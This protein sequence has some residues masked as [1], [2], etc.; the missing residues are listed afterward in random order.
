MLAYMGLAHIVHP[1]TRAANRSPPGLLV[2]SNVGRVDQQ[3]AIPVLRAVAE[4][5]A[6]LRLLLLYGSRARGDAHERSDWDVGYLG[7]DVDHL[8]LLADVTSALGTDDVDLVDF[9]RASGLLTFRAAREGITVYER[10]PGIWAEFALTA[11]LHWYDVEP[12][13]RRTHADLLAGLH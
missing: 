2:G 6:G 5:H 7:T 9:R 12:V 10:V 13:V 11:A 1:T 8:G 4:K 3:P